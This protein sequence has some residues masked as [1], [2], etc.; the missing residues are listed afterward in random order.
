MTQSPCQSCTRIA[1]PAQCDN[2]RCI[3]WQL[4]F[5]DRWASI[6]GYYLRHKEKRT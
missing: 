6:H 1:D 4:W 5:A 2:K 3:P